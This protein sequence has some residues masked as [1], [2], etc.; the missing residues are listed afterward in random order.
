MHPLSMNTESRRSKDGEAES[1]V[2]GCPSLRANGTVQQPRIQGGV[3][4]G[5]DMACFGCL[6]TNCKLLHGFKRRRASLL[7]TTLNPRRV[8]SQSHPLQRVLQTCK[9]SWTCAYPSETD[10]AAPP[11]QSSPLLQ[12]IALF[13]TRTLCSARSVC[14]GVVATSSALDHEACA[15]SRACFAFKTSLTKPASPN[16]RATPRRGFRL[17]HPAFPWTPFSGSGWLVQAVA[18]MSEDEALVARPCLWCHD[19][20]GPQEEAVEM[21]CSVCQNYFV[22]RECV[23]SSTCLPECTL[24]VRNER[25]LLPR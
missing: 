3:G 22:H 2:A 1:V 6:R 7:S 5:P 17:A 9:L 25:A 12:E 15:F 4:Y 16:S 20:I 14:E 23:I 10:R 24:A 19:V 18:Y 13:R 21:E 8:P 11:I